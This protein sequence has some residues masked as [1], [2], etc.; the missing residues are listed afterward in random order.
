MQVY[1]GLCVSVSFIFFQFYFMC[2]GVCLHVCLYT[3]HMPCAHRDQKRVLDPL[4]MELF[5]TVGHHLGAKNKNPCPLE[6]CQVPS[7]TEPSLHPFSIFNPVD[8]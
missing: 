5:K 8:Q 7:T 2:L 4:V 3:M 6:E 1:I